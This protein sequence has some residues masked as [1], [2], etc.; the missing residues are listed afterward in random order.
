MWAFI[1]FTMVVIFHYFVD[2]LIW[3]MSDYPELG[4]L[5]LPPKNLS[6]K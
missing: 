3:K 1:P 2:G 5:L 6:Q 4:K